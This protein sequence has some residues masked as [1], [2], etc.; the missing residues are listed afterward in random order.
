M[1][2]DLQAPK[3][4]YLVLGETGSYDD[5][6]DWTVAAFSTQQAADALAKRLNNWCKENPYNRNC[7]LDPNY[8]NDYPATNY[9]VV[10]VEWRE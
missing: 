7:P 5:F 6:R 8:Q 3:F 4:V 10:P 9:T 2:E 1:T